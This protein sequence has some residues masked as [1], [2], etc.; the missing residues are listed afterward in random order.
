MKGFPVGRWPR[1]VGHALGFL[2]AGLILLA[3]S[4]GARAQDP[5]ALARVRDLNKKAV[6]AYENLELEEARKSLMTALEICATEGLNRH[7]LKAQT[8]LNLGVVL[9]GG[10]KQRDAGTKQ[11]KR[12]LEIDPNIRV[13]KR[14]ANP[15][16]TGAFN[17]AIREMSGGAPSAPEAPTTPTPP[18]STTPTP[19]DTTTAPKPSGPASATA[20]VHNPVTDARPNEELPIKASI[21]ETLRFDRVV[22]AYRPEGASDFLARDMEPETGTEYVARIPEPATRGGSVSYY[23]EARGRGGQALARNGSPDEPHV[24][25]LSGSGP[26]AGVAQVDSG[27][28][29]GE[30]EGGMGGGGNRFWLAMGIGAG[31]GY[32]KG[33]PEVNPNYLDGTVAR[34]LDFSGMAGAKLLHFVPEVGYFV[35]PKLLLSVQG[36]LQYTTGATEVHHPSCG[37]TAVCKPATGAVAVLGRATWFL[38]KGDKLQPYVSLLAGG[39]YIRYLVDLSQQLGSTCGPGAADTCRDTVAGGGLLAGPAA[40]ILYGLTPDLFLSGG[41]NA[42]LGLPKTA[43]NFDLNVGLGYRL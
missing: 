16:I 6:D 39:G 42:L 1:A 9:V 3:V 29:P 15:D 26:G 38:G 12:A 4:P 33:S 36:R 14:L 27:E 24:I 31:G 8:H 17:D 5:E 11:F 21:E 20:I 43:F 2:V 19:P 18:T 32:A 37:D 7:T 25:T 40:G 10:A 28:R 30:E 22:L 23:I 41:V 34:P 13:P 35:S